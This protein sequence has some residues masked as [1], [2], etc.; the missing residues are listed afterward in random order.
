MK[1]KKVTFN[2]IVEI[3]YFNKE[4]PI[5]K[6]SYNYYLFITGIL[7]IIIISLLL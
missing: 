3:R 7:I 1:N 6:K 2:D 5:I 4:E